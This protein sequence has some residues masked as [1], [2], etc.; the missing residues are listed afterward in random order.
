MELLSQ[1]PD[2]P[3]WPSQLRHPPWSPSGMSFGPLWFCAYVSSVLETEKML[4]SVPVK[5]KILVDSHNWAFR[6]SPN[7]EKKDPHLH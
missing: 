1:T 5:G 3:E 2:I 4:K 6:Q 7:P